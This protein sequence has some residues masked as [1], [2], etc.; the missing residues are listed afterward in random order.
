LKVAFNARFLHSPTLRGWN[1]Y[2]VN[3][4]AE[5]PEFGV[6][7]YLYTDK[8]IHASHL[9]RLK[10][11][12][13]QVRQSAPM[14][15][16]MWEQFWL[17]QQCERD[18]VD[19][20]HCPMNFG[21]PW[22]SHCPRVLT[23]HDAIDQVYYGSRMSWRERFA[24]A[25]LTSRLYHW[26]ARTRAEQVIT[27]SEYS[28]TDLVRYLGIPAG[29]IAV[30]HEAADERFHK[31]VE[32]SD[33]ELIRR[34]YDLSRPYVFYVG[35]WELRK[36]LPF[37]IRSFAAAGL[38]DVELVLAGGNSEQRENLAALATSLGLDGRL[39]LLGWVDDQHL[40]ALYA[41]ATCFV[42]PS[43]YEGFGLQLC[44]AMAAGCPVL[45]ADSTCLPEVLG[46]GGVI[47]PPG[48]QAALAALLK[49][50]TGCGSCRE[51]LAV[52]ARR[53]AGDF[54]WRQTADLTAQVYRRVL[55][56]A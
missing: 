15:Y 32:R 3:L 54:S 11:G 52:R 6:E 27:V 8:P 12:S 42:Y 55:E 35:G 22:R 25:A 4:L 7:L 38:G 24:P 20:L 23:L 21:L 43:E 40:P 31:P 50:V 36:N 39:R 44:E 48:D 13:F 1:R 2:T 41:E 49:Q 30:I 5:L 19:V 16:V 33:R 28:K 34:E 47:F 18:G 14:K 29:R 37:L 17:P 26:A 45:A 56:A 53:R 51:D 46:D 9:A 10:S